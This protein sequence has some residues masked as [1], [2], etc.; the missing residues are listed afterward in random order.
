MRN[1]ERSRS[2][3]SSVAADAGCS[4]CS[5][6]SLLAS[7]RRCALLA[8]RLR[9]WL[10]HRRER[11]AVSGELTRDCDHDDQAWLASGLER[12]PAPVQSARARVRLDSHGERLAGASA[13]QRDAQPRGASLMPGGFDQKPARVRVAGLGNPALTAALPA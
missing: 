12:V 4:Q 10:L 5:L 9:V 13:F 11:P 2:L 7:V 3:A 1:E 6:G 8:E